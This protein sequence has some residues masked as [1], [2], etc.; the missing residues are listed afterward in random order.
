MT[1]W[2]RA[3]DNSPSTN[4]I[5]NSCKSRGGIVAITILLPF[6]LATAAAWLQHTDA[7]Q[8]L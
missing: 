5:M 6:A 3:A 2:Y 4:S 7:Y 1:H 8:D